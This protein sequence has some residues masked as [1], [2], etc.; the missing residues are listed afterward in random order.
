MRRERSVRLFAKSPSQRL[1][2][3]GLAEVVVSARALRLGHDL[4]LA[5]RARGA[6]QGI[7]CL[8][9]TDP[10][11]VGASGFKIDQCFLEPVEV[12]RAKRRNDIEPVG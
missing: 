5:G 1:P 11:T 9:E 8:T 10:T 4:Q 7:A 6:D 12:L 3:R 2:S